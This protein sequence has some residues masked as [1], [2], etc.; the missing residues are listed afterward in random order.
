[1]IIPLP[2]HTYYSFHFGTIPPARLMVEAARLGY[3]ALAV[4]DREGIFGMPTFY[5]AAGKA[6]IRPIAGV[7][8][9][10]TDGSPRHVHDNCIILAKN[11]RGFSAIS[12]ILTERALCLP[13]GEA[14][15]TSTMPG[16]AHALGEAG[17]TVVA[18]TTD[19]RLL[20][21][22]RGQAERYALL[23]AAAR[24]SWKKL[25]AGAAANGIKAVAGPGV[26]FLS[27][28]DR[29]VQ[30]LLVAIG[31][32]ATIY[33]VADS[34]LAPS[35][36]CLASP[37]A[38]AAPFR[39]LPETITNNEAVAEACSLDS[40][41]NGW[42]F[43]AWPT[44]H[45]GGPAGLLRDLTLAGTAR[46]LG[47]IPDAYRARIDYELGIISEKSF[48]DYFLVV[49]DIVSRASRTCGRGS[50]AASIV[51]WAL[52]ITDVDP[53]RHD[54]YFERFLNPGRSDPPDIDVDFAWDER[55]KLL[56]DVVARYGE[57]HTARVANH[58]TFRHR[59][60]LR[61]TARAFGIPDSETGGRERGL[62]QDPGAASIHD[63]AGA[64]SIHDP[65]GAG[66][67]ADPTWKAITELSARIVGFPRNIGTHSGGVVI[68]PGALHDIVPLLKTGSGIRVTAWDKEGVE[69]AGLV[70]ID[71]LGNRS[72]AVVRDATANV[73]GSPD[74]CSRPEDDSA[75]IALL[76]RGD[77][78]GVFYVESPAMR[79]LQKKTGAGDFA[80][81]VIHS[82]IIRP[83]ANRYINEYIDRHLG[84]PWTHIHPL[85]SGILDE[86]H[87]LMCYQ[88]DVSK[89]AVAL[90]GFTPAEADGMRKVLSKKDAVTRLDSWLPKFQDGA[91]ARG[92]DD[93]KI[94]EIWDMIQSFAGYSFVKAHS[95][96]YARLSF[97]SAWLRA[98][99]PA[100][101]MAAV[102]SNRGGYYG[103]LAYASEARRMGLALLP[104][105][106][107][108]SGRRAKG[109][110]GTIRFGLESI[111]GLSEACMDRIVAERAL[112]GAFASALD[113]A[114]RVWPARDDAEALAESGALDTLSPGLRRPEKLLCI[115]SFAATR[116]ASG[117]PD[118]Q[119]AGSLFQDQPS[120]TAF[121]GEAREVAGPPPEN[122]GSGW[123]AAGVSRRTFLEG[124]MRRIGTTLSVHPLE[125]WPGALA[126][127]RVL[128]RDLAS[129]EGRVVRLVGWPVTAKEV[130]A[131]GEL[132]MEFVSFED[133]TAIYEA[134]LFPDTYRRFGALLFEERPFI[135]TGKVCVDR[136]G[137]SLELRN[138]ER[139]PG[140]ALVPPGQ[141]KAFYGRYW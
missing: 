101:F 102:M 94:A 46:R 35:M 28:S 17:D 115:L 111:G 30:R 83:A 127:Q 38:L 114:R 61:E 92:V 139:V 100:E 138:L 130:L 22:W 123:Q 45:P 8:L 13:G 77:T 11:R 51:S 110:V 112:S 126:S 120:V 79:L 82:S 140:R 132:P 72:L 62:S 20:D 60:A 69:A 67:D 125:L 134:V 84:K 106:V 70:K 118:A 107:Q 9:G 105:S 59:G 55:D 122:S 136:G 116:E 26:S 48:A 12:R 88:E 137:L 68:V 119:G 50:A 113:F 108:D 99:H 57:A 141:A 76:A 1:M 135:I 40:L 29:E 7:E 44:D 21:S 41:F 71:L 117:R 27:P 129:K 66:R 95:A 58:V 96:S 47:S 78:M 23:P 43:P 33:E 80:H 98:H 34:E 89:V 42:H 97:R 93:A 65:A 90:A 63:P 103:I 91:R 64:A 73:A 86:A 133:E 109:S 6:G 37:A 85:L 39:D 131:Q 10:Y 14:D 49:R 128:A 3:S 74:L 54:L 24:G 31:K 52:E 36:A 32:T 19:A 25:L 124:Q 104:P 18:L 81:L 87:G 53:L 121:P 56:A 5:E 16:L 15:S 2:L 4:T 75:T